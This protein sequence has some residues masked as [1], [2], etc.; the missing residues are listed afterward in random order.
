QKGIVGI[1]D[2]AV[3][4]A[5]LGCLRG[6]LGGRGHDEI[7]QAVEADL[8]FR[9]ADR[10]AYMGVM[11]EDQVGPGAERR[12]RDG[13]LVIGDEAWDEVDA[14]VERQDAPVR[15]FAGRRCP[16]P[17]RRGRPRTAR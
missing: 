5:E 16:P 6:R 3:L 12:L 1:Q 15:R 7:A 17:W 13:N 10:L 4:P 9:D 14:P 8:A 2:N 11:A